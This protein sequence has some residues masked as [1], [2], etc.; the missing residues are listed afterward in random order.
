MYFVC[1]QYVLAEGE[2]QKMTTH[3]AGVEGM[4]GSNSDKDGAMDAGFEIEDMFGEAAFI[5]HVVQRV[6]GLWEATNAEALRRAQT[7]VLVVPLNLIYRT[8]LLVRPVLRPYSS[9]KIV[10][11]TI[12]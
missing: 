11:C 4:E 1:P 9:F 6:P 2:G 5:A 7:Y 12:K 3:G 8:L 10:G